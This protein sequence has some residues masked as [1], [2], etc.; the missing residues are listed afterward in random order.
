MPRVYPAGHNWQ[1]KADKTPEKRAAASLTLSPSVKVLQPVVLDKGENTETVSKEEEKVEKKNSVPSQASR[2][3]K[4][5]QPIMLVPSSYPS[6]STFSLHASDE[7]LRC[8][9][10]LPQPQPCSQV[11]NFPNESSVEIFSSRKFP[12][13]LT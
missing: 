9:G 1:T 13:S 7:G 5:T 12:Y 8:Q 3:A 11:C 4:T 6:L 10:T 2:Q